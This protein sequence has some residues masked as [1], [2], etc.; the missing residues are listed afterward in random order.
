MGGSM[1]AGR[2]VRTCLALPVSEWCK[3]DVD[4]YI[5]YATIDGQHLYLDAIRRK[6]LQP[7]APTLLYFHGGAWVLGDKACHSLPLLYNITLKMGWL[8]LSANYRLSYTN[9]S[10][11]AGGAT[12]P[13]HLHDC[14]RAVAWARGPDARKYGGGGRMLAIG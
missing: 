4:R 2:V 7:G 5:C 6:G 1:S 13:E 14:F 12:F 10:T 9:F 3:L 8:V 11:K